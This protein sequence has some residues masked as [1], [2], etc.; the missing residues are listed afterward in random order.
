MKKFILV[1][2]SLFL[3]LFSYGQ[4]QTNVISQMDS[5]KYQGQTEQYCLIVCTARLFSTKVNVDLD[6]GQTTNFFSQ[7]RQRQIIDDTG[8]L[9]KFDSVVDALHFLNARGWV[10]VAA[11]PM[12]SSQG[13]CYHYLV[14]RTISKDDL[15]TQ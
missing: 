5:V 15:A 13:Q 10:F 6:F 2:A 4:D 1:C 14:K 3:S 8:K 7:T 11:Y 9:K 12:S